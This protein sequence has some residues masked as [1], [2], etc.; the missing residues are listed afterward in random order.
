MSI[1]ILTTFVSYWVKNIV[2]CTV[3]VICTVYSYTFFYRIIRIVKQSYGEGKQLYEFGFTLTKC[4]NGAPKIK[5]SI[6]ILQRN[7]PQ[8]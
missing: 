3:N 1:S 7:I 6:L 4:E 8:K 5:I 2:Y